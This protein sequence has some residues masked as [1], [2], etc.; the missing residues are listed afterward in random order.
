[1]QYE[2]EEILDKKFMKSNDDKRRL[3]YLIKWKGYSL[4]HNTWESKSELG[5]AKEIIKEF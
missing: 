5:N 4:E 3:Y 2:I 1:M